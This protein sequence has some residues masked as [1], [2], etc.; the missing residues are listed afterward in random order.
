[1]NR[2]LERLH[3]RIEQLS[4]EMGELRSRIDGLEEGEGPDAGAPGPAESR[5]EFPTATRGAA[6]DAEIAKLPTRTIALVGRTL[7]VL[8]GAYLFRAISD[9]GVVPAQIG[10]IVALLYA[11]WWLVQADRSA[12]APTTSCL[13]QAW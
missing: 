8:G 13:R 10:A 11:A 6:R 4:R 12:V 2:D 5:T 3:E 7:I 9:T 1:M